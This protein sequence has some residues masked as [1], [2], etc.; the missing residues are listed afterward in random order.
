MHVLSKW[1]VKWNYV[2]L[3]TIIPN[4]IEIT[5]HFINLVLIYELKLFLTTQTQT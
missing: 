1:K 3:T 5:H 4:L 2:P